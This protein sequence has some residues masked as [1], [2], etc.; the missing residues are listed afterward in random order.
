MTDSKAWWAKCENI[1]REGCVPVGE[2]WWE[3][4]FLARDYDASEARVKELKDNRDGWMRSCG[5]WKERALAAEADRDRLAATVERVR[6]LARRLRDSGTHANEACNIENALADEQE[7]QL[8]HYCAMCECTYDARLS[9]SR[10][11]GF[12]KCVE[13]RKSTRRAKVYPNTIYRIDGSSH[14]D[15]RKA[16]SERR[17]PPATFPRCRECGKWKAKT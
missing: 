6:A 5:D 2:T 11:H 3:R 10:N 1:I 4:V 9:P 15:C 13:R 17:K 14:D 12:G 7:Q 8:D 16:G